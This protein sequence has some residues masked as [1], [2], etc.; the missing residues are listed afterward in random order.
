[1]LST[2]VSEAVAKACNCASLGLAFNAIGL[3][4]MLLWASAEAVPASVNNPL[5]SE[6]P[7]QID[8]LTFL[9]SRSS[10]KTSHSEA[11][12]LSSLNKRQCKYF[13]D[14]IVL[15]RMKHRNSVIAAKS[16]DDSNNNDESSILN[17]S[18]DLHE[19][20]V[21]SF[22]HNIRIAKTKFQQDKNTFA[23][24]ENTK[25]NYEIVRNISHG[26]KLMN[27]GE[28]VSMENTS[29]PTLVATSKKSDVKT[30]AQKETSDKTYLHVNG[31]FRSVAPFSFLFVPF[32]PQSLASKLENARRERE[33]SKN[34]FRRLG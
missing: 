30:N 14:R 8:V 23:S 15:K 33:K 25:A 24:Y 5:I 21:R 34:F 10:N 27:N 12:C 2:I 32:F 31:E 26:D 17:N 13:E 20:Q 6:H 28:S 22:E 18:K 4:L 1:M 19:R 9:K 11:D 7:S 29:E 3:F 16:N